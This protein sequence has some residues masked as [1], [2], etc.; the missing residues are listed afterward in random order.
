[1]AKAGVLASTPESIS[2]P[3]FAQG[4]EVPKPELEVEEEI[5]K[6]VRSSPSLY[7]EPKLA[8]PWTERREPG[9]EVAI[10]TL[11][12]FT[13]KAGLSDPSLPLTSRVEVAMR[14]LVV[15]VA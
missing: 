9:A 13:K 3:N 11:S 12:S 7:R 15:V 4:E 5:R 8:N 6:E 10:P 14:E 2:M 1:M